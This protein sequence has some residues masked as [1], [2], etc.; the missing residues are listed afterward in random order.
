MGYEEGEH[1]VVSKMQLGYPR[2][3]YVTLGPQHN[4]HSMG[5]A[6]FF[7]HPIIQGLADLVVQQHGMPHESALLLSTHGGARRCQAFMEGYVDASERNYLRILDFV[8]IPANVEVPSVLEPR[9][10]AVLFPQY[11][12]KHAKLFWQ[13]TGEGVSSRRGEYCKQDLERGLIVERL[14][15][16][17]T[18]RQTRAPKRYRKINSPVDG[19]NAISKE[20]GNSITNGHE[21]I[22]RARFVEERFGRNL[23]MDH[24]CQAKLAVRRRI[25]GSLTADTELSEALSLAPDSGRIRDVAGFSVDDV[26]LYQNGMNSIFNTHRKIM[27]ARGPM[28]SICYGYG[29]RND[30]S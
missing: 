16:E 6:R 11:M 20:N 13:H 18:K 7:I 12:F 14:K 28:K 5:H 19:A 15:A 29:S 10:S 27:L 23:N 1:W 25:A 21:T 26:Y 8:H 2:F 17:E 30:S 4:S 9:F 22:D 3:D 24:V